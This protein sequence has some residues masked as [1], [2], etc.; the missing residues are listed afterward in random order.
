MKKVVILS[1]GDS[2]GSGSRISNAIN[3]YCKETSSV[4][5][6]N[7]SK[8]KIGHFNPDHVI[9]DNETDL[10]K[11]QK[12]I[13]NA[14]IIHFKDDE[15]LSRDWNGIKIPMITPIVHTAGGSSFRGHD[16]EIEKK[17]LIKTEKINF[18]PNW[19][20]QK[21]LNG[22]YIHVIGD[23]MQINGSL[24][25]SNIH[26]NVWS[27][28]VSVPSDANSII[29]KGNT[30]LINTSENKT[31]D[32]RSI[33]IRFFNSEG[34]I[35][36]TKKKNTGSLLGK[37]TD[38]RSV[39]PIP[40]GSK[41]V[42]YSFFTHKI[43]RINYLV[44]N[45]EIGF[46][47]LPNSK[48]ISLVS[49]FSVANGTWDLEAYSLASIK[50]VLTPDLLARDN[51]RRI[52]PHVKPQINIRKK[53]KKGD[54]IIISHAPSNTGKKGTAEFIIPAIESLSKEY[55]IKFNLIQ[56]LTHEECL[57]EISKSDIFI[58][59][60]V[61]GYYGNAGLEAMTMGIPVLVY[62]N[63][64]TINLAKGPW[65]DI[66]VLRVKELTVEAVI[67][68]LRPVLENENELKLSAK[69]CKDWSNRIHS[70]KIIANM[71]ENI[72]DE[73]LNEE[74]KSKNEAEEITDVKIH[75]NYDEIFF[76]GGGSWGS[77]SYSLKE[78]EISDITLGIEKTHNNRV[79]VNFNKSIEELGDIEIEF[80]RI[81]WYGGK[82]A[83][84][85]HRKKLSLDNLKNSIIKENFRYMCRIDEKWPAGCYRVVANNNSFGRLFGHFIVDNQ[86][87]KN[88]N[89]L[90]FPHI[91]SSLRMVKNKGAMEEIY[92]TK[93]NSN[94]ST[95]IN[96]SNN[97]GDTEGSK[98]VNWLFPTLM[99]LEKNKIPYKLVN[100]IDI[101]NTDFNLSNIMS[102]IFMG[103]NHIWTKPVND[104]VKQHISKNN[105]DLIILGSGMGQELAYVTNDKRNA[106]LPHNE[107][108]ESR[109]ENWKK[110]NLPIEISYEIPRNRFFSE[111]YDTKSQPIEINSIID[112]YK[113]NINFAEKIFSLDGEEYGEISSRVFHLKNGSKFFN[114]GIMEFPKLLLDNNDNDNGIS[115]VNREL[116]SLLWSD[117]SMYT[118][119]ELIFH[120]F[121][122]NWEF[123]N[124][125]KINKKVPKI[126]LIM[127]IWKRPELTKKVMEHYMNMKIKLKGKID[128]INI[129]IG[130]EGEITRK[131]S[132]KFNFQYLEYMN[133]PLS[134][135]WDAGIMESKK[136]D[137][138]AVLIVGS[139]DIIDS[140]LL[141][142]LLGKLTEGRLVVGI[143]DF[144][145]FDSN[146][147]KLMYWPGYEKLNHRHGE[148]IGL[149]R[150]ISK[151]LLVKINYKIWE[152]LEI[153]KG[154]DLA[155]TNKFIKFGL[156][157][158][159]NSNEVFIKIGDNRISLAHSG[160]YLKELSGFAIDIKS[161][162]NIT[163]IESYKMKYKNND[164]PELIEK[165]KSM[166]K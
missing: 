96:I 83:R 163:P 135:K 25:N 97:E 112:R 132:E 142:S 37:E 159:H 73:L 64:K 162:L 29:I 103:D 136:Y 117:G 47:K 88:T 75:N 4:C 2:A 139:D 121:K 3:K 155:M 51:K 16:F 115:K 153:D 44:K 120:N 90:I 15:P 118:N 144:Y 133:S 146:K 21:R 13:D 34:R 94:G 160:F 150:L 92:G 61:A 108:N 105:G 125:N 50:T 11:I 161:E 28:K 9:G 38:F 62:I 48:L 12:I 166:V 124:I 32:I 6:V 27:N 65:L 79:F 111:S 80:F 35:I 110:M 104:L 19:K 14:D 40:E 151:D 85:V 33:I 89:L 46:Y 36:E 148:T 74:L 54:G 107:E 78:N 99:W 59:Q 63:D 68:T 116:K 156:L 17:E 164:F 165:L 122:K 86:S 53:K 109:N 45:C 39:F 5:I 82:G 8:R 41:T 7:R 30:K 10:I 31:Y 140:D 20:T 18:D 22:R 58:D 137:P 66:P 57:T 76:R 152:D 154:L 119:E 49:Q 114:A 93:S 98:I 77:T 129:S 131:M 26:N 95:R 23:S 81:G 113:E 123:T 147:E 42:R 101:I 24:F 100:D 145:I 127:P 72:Y 52:T 130:S 128:L 126:C 91:T 134:R 56:N 149:C 67:E 138:D 71:W 60:M 84:T 141:I 157:P 69:K 1:E 143:L 158:M 87:K 43:Y 70:P 106:I 102:L 55:N